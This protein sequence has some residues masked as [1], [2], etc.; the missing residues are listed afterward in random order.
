MTKIE[1]PVFDIPQIP[2]KPLPISAWRALNVELVRRLKL[3]GKYARLRE[4]PAHQPAT[5]AFRLE[6]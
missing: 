3:S 6:D 2:R 4:S 1:L 5:A